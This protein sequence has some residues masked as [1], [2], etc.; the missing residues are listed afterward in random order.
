MADKDQASSS[1]KKRGPKVDLDRV[2]R[3][4]EK[5]NPKK[6]GTAAHK[7]YATYED[8]MTVGEALKK[9]ITLRDIRHDT[10][11]KYIE[12]QVAQSEKAQ[13]QA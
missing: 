3:I 13:K 10:R 2:I 5:K 1:G 4:V 8:G 6:E 11:Q 7:R 12:C 9:G